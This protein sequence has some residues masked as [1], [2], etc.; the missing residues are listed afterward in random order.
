M[1]TAAQSTLQ[2]LSAEPSMGEK[3]KLNRVMRHSICF[4]Q[5]SSGVVDT[6]EVHQKWKNLAEISCIHYD[7]F[8]HMTK[9]VGA[10]Q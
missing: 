7:D 10:R 8:C 6:K 3:D 9:V 5:L 1:C 4:R 2:A